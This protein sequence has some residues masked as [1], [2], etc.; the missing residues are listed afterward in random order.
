[1]KVLITEII[2]GVQVTTDYTHY[3]VDGS[4]TVE[5]SVNVPTLTSFQ[6]CNVDDA[7]MVPKR[8][9]YVEIITEIY[10]GSANRKPGLIYL[11]AP[12]NG[13]FMTDNGSGQV[14]QS[15]PTSPGSAE[16]TAI[17]ASLYVQNGSPGNILWHNIDQNGNDTGFFVAWPGTHIY[18]TMLGT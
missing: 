10:T 13:Y 7:F 9:A 2:N 6:L 16:A 3:V 1:M 5:D 8:G 18:P 11:S 14:T 15:Y 4:I 12:V 17:G